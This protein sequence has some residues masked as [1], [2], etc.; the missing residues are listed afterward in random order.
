MNTFYRVQIVYV[1]MSPGLGPKPYRINGN[2]GAADIG[3]SLVTSSLPKQLRCL[4]KKKL[5]KP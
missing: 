5:K 1:N 3:N 4:F 2:N